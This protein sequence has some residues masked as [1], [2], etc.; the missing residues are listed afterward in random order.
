MIR[1]ST[2]ASSVDLMQRLRR[3][4][5]EEL[6]VEIDLVPHFADAAV[7]LVEGGVVDPG[8]EYVRPDFAQEVADEVLLEGDIFVNL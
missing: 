1:C 8:V 7:L 5:L 3:L 6:S 4:V 2:A